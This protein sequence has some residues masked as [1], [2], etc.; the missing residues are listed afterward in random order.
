MA[1]LRLEILPQPDDVTCGPTALH[2]VY[3]YFDDGI[4]LHD[5]IAQTKML[6]EGGTL[7][8]MLACHALTRGYTATI[9][10]YNLN[11]FDPTWFRRGVDLAAKLRR[12]AELKP[13]DRQL[14]WATDG[15]LE[16]LRLGGRV[17]HTDLTTGLLR[18][19][20]KRGVPILAGLNSTF[21]YN[22]AREIGETNDY[23]DLRGEPAGHFVVLAR[24]DKVRRQVLIA[25][26]LGDNPTFEPHMY[27]VRMPR[28][29]ASIL[30]GVLTYDASLLIIEPKRSRENGRD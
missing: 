28:L 12:Q 29:V 15:Y 14:R 8:V 21:L 2:A 10:A 3:R 4:P 11:V 30:L 6:E 16:F 27:W 23:D 17:R 22:C 24:Y 26:P 19:Y 9:Y 5:V 1:N 20:L 7:A 13:D 18:G 25:D